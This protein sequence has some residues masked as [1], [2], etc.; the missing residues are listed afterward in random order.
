M[1]VQ[2]DLDPDVL[3]MVKSIAAERRATI[4]KVISDLLREHL[5]PPTPTRIRNGFPLFETAAKDVVITNE[6]IDRIKSGCP[7]EQDD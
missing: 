2:A 3:R 6:H 4:G 7:E 1:R 5:T